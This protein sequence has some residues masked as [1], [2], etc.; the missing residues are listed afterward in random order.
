MS[1]VQSIANVITNPRLQI[2]EL[3]EFGGMALGSSRRWLRGVGGV[4]GTTGLTLLLGTGCGVGGSTPPPTATAPA[5][6]V[7]VSGA[8]PP[9]LRPET[10]SLPAALIADVDE[11]PGPSSSNVARQILAGLRA[12]VRASHGSATLP[13]GDASSFRRVAGGLRPQFTAAAVTPA[14]RVLLP[15]RSDGAVRLEDVATGA[16]VAVTLEGGRDV[17]P[18]MASGYLVYRRGHASGATVLHRASPA[19]VEDWLSFDERPATPEVTY[20]LALGAGVAG[21][22]LVEN[23]LE[24]LDVRGA[25]RLRVEPP[26]LVGAD[27]ERTAATLALEGCSVDR[28]PA[29]PWD[30]AVTAPRSASCGLRVSWSNE[31][32]AY[33]ALLDPRW[34]ATTNTMTASRQKHTATLLASGKVLVVG[35]SSGSAALATAELFDRTTGTWATTASLTGARQSHAAVL[36]GSTG[37]TTTSGKVLVTGGLNGTTSQNTAQLYD[38][39]AGTW[40]AAA[41]LPAGRHLH[42]ATL[43][44]NGQVLIAG[45]LTGTATLMTAAIYNPASGTGSWTATG[46]MQSAASN[47]TATLLSVPGNASLNNTVLVVGGNSGSSTTAVVQVLSGTTWSSS[48]LVTQLPAARE[49]HTATLLANGNVLITGGK[50]GA[51]TLNTTTVFNPSSGK[52]TWTA[53]GNLTAARQQHTATL[54]STS[55]LA[56]GQ[57]LVSGGSSGSASLSSTELWNGTSWTP[58]TALLSAVQGHTAT[59][60]ANGMVLV[61]GGVNG[62]TTVNAAALYDPSWASTCTTNSQCATGFC[63]NGVCCDTA[64]NGGCGACNLTGKVGTCSALPS[65]TTCR[66]ANGTCDVAETCS[67]TALT[68]PTD[69]FLPSTTTCRAANGTCD[70][71]EKCTGT[72]AACP[73]DAFLPST[74]TCRAATGT[75][76][77]AEKC[78]GT[79]AACPTDTFLPSTTTCRASTGT[80]D[81]AEACTGTSAACPADVLSPSTTVCRA[82]NGACDVAEKCTGTSGACPADVLSPST[83]VCRAA[84]GTCDVAESCTGTS[85]ACPADAFLPS[86]TVCRAANGTCD[87]AE[88]CTGTSAACPADGFAPSSTICRP[89]A[90][91]CDLNETCTGASASCPADQLKQNGTVCDDGQT[92]T[93]NDQCT[94]GVCGGTMVA[95]PMQG[96]CHLAGSCNPQTG[97]CFN[98]EAPNGSTCDDGDPATTGEVCEA[99]ACRVPTSFQQAAAFAPTDLGSLGGSVTNPLAMNDLGQIVGNA[100]TADGS[101]RAFV[102]APPGP[103]QNLSAPLALLPGSIANDVNDFSVVVGT[104]VESSGV[105]H[106][107]RYAWNGALLPNTGAAGSSGA[108]GG[109]ASS[110]VGGGSGSS[111][112]GGGSA[113]GSGVSAFQDLG[114]IGDEQPDQFGDR[115]SY[116]VAVNA[117]GDIVGTF[118]ANGDVQTFRYTAAT[119]NIWNIGGLYG[120]QTIASDIS[121]SGT[122]VGVSWVPNA[123]TGGIRALGHGFINDAISPGEIDINQYVDPTSGWT[124]VNARSISPDGTYIVGSGDRGG[125]LRGYRLNRTTGVLDELST[126]WSGD[127]FPYSVNNSGQVVGTGFPTSSSVLT[128]WLYTDQ[129]GFERLDAVSPT[130]GW[131]FSVAVAING[132]GSITGYGTYQGQMR[133]FSM[134]LGTS[135][136]APCAAADQCHAS[137]GCDPSRGTCTNP[138]KPN[139]TTCDDGNAATSDETCQVGQCRSPSS[140]LAISG[141]E[142]DDIGQ[143]GGGYSNA[144][145]INSFGEVVG[146]STTADGQYHAFDWQAPG[147]IID[148]TAQG[149]FLTNSSGNAINDDGTSS[150]GMSSGSEQHAYILDVNGVHDLG[151][152]GD[153]SVAPD[154]AG[155]TQQG[156]SADGMNASGQLTGWFTKKQV[157][158]AF[159]YTDGI[160]FEDVP[161]LAGGETLGFAISNAGV[162][163][164]SS[165]VPGSAGGFSA[166]RLG[167][168]FMWDGVSETSVDLND[169]IDPSM[170]ITIHLAGGFSPNGRWISGTAERNGVLIAYRLDTTTG[171]LDEV[172]NGWPGDSYG[173]PVNDHGDVSGWGHPDAANQI[174]KAFIYTDDVGFKELDTIIDP[175][176]GWDLQVSNAINASSQ[177]VGW[178]VYQSEYRGFRLGKVVSPDVVCANK[179]EGDSCDVGNTC[180]SNNVC[181]FGVCGGP[182]PA[183]N[184]C[185]RMDGIVEATPGTWIAVFGY[186]NNAKDVVVPE[187]DQYSV[188]GNL[189]SDPS[190]PPPPWLAVGSHPGAFLPAFQLGQTLSWR[191]NGQF[192]T[193]DSNS[194]QLTK[195]TDE[196]GDYVS[197]AGQRIPLPPVP[198]TEIQPVP[199]C[200]LTDSSGN[201]AVFGYSNSSGHA[202]TV[203]AGDKNFV[204]IAGVDISPTISLPTFFEATGKPVAFY[205][206]FSSGP[207]GWTIGTTRAEINVG[208]TATCQM[209]TDAQGTWVANQ[210]GQSYL[211]IPDNSTTLAASIVAP[212]KLSDGTV[213]GKTEGAFSVTA[214]GTSSYDVPLWV[215]MGQGGLQPTL[216]VDYD[217]AREDTILGVGFDLMGLS[218]QVAR[219]EK[220]FRKDGHTGAIKFDDTDAYCLDG[221]R[222]VPQLDGT[223]RKEADDS[224][225]ITMQESSSSA[226]PDL[227]VVTTATGVKYTY[228]GGGATFGG[229]RTQITYDGSGTMTHT[230]TEVRYAWS[231][232]SVQDEFGN[233]MDYT[234]D[235]DPDSCGPT[236]PNCYHWHR[237]NNIAYSGGSRVVRFNYEGRI[238]DVYKNDAGFRT[239]QDQLLTSIDVL[240][241]K[242]GASVN[243]NFLKTYEFSFNTGTVSGRTRLQSLVECDG[244]KAIGTRTCKQPTT[245]QWDD[246]SPSYTEQPVVPFVAGRQP[247]LVQAADFDGD[248]RD[249]IV[250]YYNGPAPFTSAI[251]LSRG[252]S[253]GSENPTEPLWQESSQEIQTFDFDRDGRQDLFGIDGSSLP[254]RGVVW[255]GVGGAVA[256]L[257]GTYEERTEVLQLAGDSEIL[258]F[259][260]DM[261]GDGLPDEMTG[262][263]TPPVAPGV[264]VIGDDR[265]SCNTTWNWELK[266]NRMADVYA[267]TI[268]EE[269]LLY[270]PPVIGQQLN[271]CLD[272]TSTTTRM[273]EGHISSR[274]ARDIVKSTGASGQD[275]DVTFDGTN[276]ATSELPIDNHVAHTDYVTDINGDGL[277]DIV[278]IPVT[279]GPPDPAVSGTVWINT[280]SGFLPSID[281]TPALFGQSSIAGDGGMRTMDCNNDGQQDFV[282]MGGT[283]INS[284]DASF[285]KCLATTGEGVYGTTTTLMSQNGKINIRPN[286][287]YNW[288][289]DFHLNQVMD[290]NGDGLDDLL[291]T[292]SAGFHIFTRNGNKPDL[293]TGVVDGQGAAVTV[294]YKPIIN[295]QYT[296]NGSCPY[297]ELCVKKD[298]WV[299]DTYALDVGFRDAPGSS[300]EMRTFQMSY[301][302]A[303]LDIAGRGWIG[304]GVVTSTEYNSDNVT[305]AGTVTREFENDIELG[306]PAYPRAGLMKKQ[307]IE[308]S[309]PTG[310][311]GGGPSRTKTVDVVRTITNT[312]VTGSTALGY[313]GVR[314]T[315]VTE[316]QTEQGA[317]VSSVETDQSYD[318]SFGYLTSRC[319]K[320]M[321][322][323]DVESWSYTFYP[324][325]PDRWVIGRPQ[326]VTHGS[327]GTCAAPSST[328]TTNYTYVGDRHDIE[329]D[330]V[331][332]G[333]GADVEVTTTYDRTSH[334]ALQGVTRQ[335]TLGNTITTSSDY[336]ADGV[337]PTVMKNAVGHVRKFV[338]HP[339]LGTLISTTD[340]NGITLAATYDTFGRLH[341]RQRADRNGVTDLNDLTV[342]YGVS[343]DIVDLVPV[344]KVTDSY[345]NGRTEEVDY[346]RVGRITTKRVASSDSGTAE[347]DATYDFRGNLSGVS[348]PH[349]TSQNDPPKWT[350]YTYDAL[351]RPA[352]TGSSEVSTPIVTF[353]Y[354]GLQTSSSTLLS[355]PSVTPARYAQRYT[356]VDDLGRVTRAGETTDDGRD[357]YTTYHYQEFSLLHDASIMGDSSNATTYGYDVLG[358]QQ[359][360]AKPDSG[361]RMF[362]YDAFGRSATTTDATGNTT[363]FNRDEA[364][365]VHQVVDQTGTA[366]L[367]WDDVPNGIG[368]NTGSSS[369][370]GVTTDSQFDTFGRPTQQTRA[371]GNDTFVTGMSYDDAGR[372]QNLTYPETPGYTTLVLTH[373]YDT[374]GALKT[375]TNSATSEVLWSIGAGLSREPGG[376][377]NTENLGSGLTSVR[378]HDPLTNFLTGVSTTLDVG[379]QQTSLQADTFSYYPNGSL[380]TRTTSPGTVETFGYDALNRL[381]DWDGGSLGWHVTY[382]YGDD[383]NLTNR[384]RQDRHSDDL[385]FNYGEGGAGRHAVTSN[386]WGSYQYDGAGRRTSAPGYAVN[387]YTNIDLPRS[388]STSSGLTTFLYDA[389]GSRFEKQS[390]FETDVYVGTLYQRIT[391]RQTGAVAHLLYVY[392]DERVV[393]MIE[394]GSGT[395]TINYQQTDNVGTPTATFNNN[396]MTRTF[397]DPFGNVTSMSDPKVPGTGQSPTGH[398]LG[399][400]SL[401][402][403]LGIINFG[404]RLYDPAVGRFLTPDPV[405]GDPTST[406]GFNPYSFVFNNPTSFRD[407]TGYQA[408]GLDTTMSIDVTGSSL[409]GENNEQVPQQCLGAGRCI[410]FPQNGPPILIMPGQP[411]CNCQGSGGGGGGNGGNGGGGQGAGAG[412]GPNLTEVMSPNGNNQGQQGGVGT[413][414]YQPWDGATNFDGTPNTRGGMKG[415]DPGGPEAGPA[416]GG[417]GN[418]DGPGTPSPG[419]GEHGSNEG[420]GPD[421]VNA[422]LGVPVALADAFR[423]IAEEGVKDLK[424]AG[425]VLVNGAIYS[426]D[427]FRGT[428]SEVR[429]LV[430]VAK[431]SQAGQLSAL[432]SLGH[433]FQGFVLLL[434]VWNCGEHDFSVRSLVQSGVAIGLMLAAP[435][436]PVAVAAVAAV[437]TFLDVTGASDALYSQFSDAPLITPQ[438]LWGLISGGGEGS[439]PP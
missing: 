388:I 92:C 405:V 196:L 123:L 438:A 305:I 186:D 167:H 179:N 13:A 435:L 304:F 234:Y 396:V 350:S 100:T 358:R 111:G 266:R 150:G 346:D 148:V 48:N 216:A 233:E 278:S 303:R 237:L 362:T 364:N 312:I 59:L 121:D 8:P 187:V 139:G 220:D 315:V 7:P 383:G 231:L 422:N 249:D 433:V 250:Y 356:D 165:W 282:F 30:R 114:V 70:V 439:E 74:T 20:R 285:V 238:K 295:A 254:R 180:A 21:L 41:N 174:Q 274:S 106:A 192:V 97:A 2:P 376:G 428:G 222:L 318:P 28:S 327:G 430:Q 207:V 301:Q 152:G 291:I 320:A 5:V 317:L 347:T 371:L 424:A 17:A 75:C 325:V 409:Y 366:T 184:V 338:Y 45:G 344:P 201:K 379:G 61:A 259:F 290:I 280:G 415:A 36:L 19:G 49:G 432:K 262:A 302:D 197:Y 307:T 173:G 223:F 72:S 322:A 181:H 397:T 221:V 402:G 18:L 55:V 352:T 219:C 154:P 382:Q 35:G 425:K 26:Y 389:A 3:R 56:N 257:P 200:V 236:T 31:D 14:T 261:N 321:F 337:Y 118:T 392:N 416:S 213:L 230:D 429:S 102:W 104:S 183:D 367:F 323:N 357:L 132:S 202:V 147:P 351:G 255:Q 339:G 267:G 199:F 263:A 171:E 76:D 177:I 393:A 360:V 105:H 90:S 418:D 144:D 83:T 272:F 120:K 172:S 308:V 252:T 368:K 372:L 333:G 159:R 348:A 38:P 208:E 155:F 54:L 129:T 189:V 297:P 268:S 412:P 276:I 119:G 399:E 330:T 331:Q 204:D 373:G 279:F 27:G 370:D 93:T 136:P 51:T 313:W 434:S 89:A 248:G 29:P 185:L 260:A 377:V 182:D 108:G 359:S 431:N 91:Q 53:S 80:C 247:G 235:N 437:L 251:R 137:G 211:L 101:T 214:N 270:E 158:H 81:P 94:N 209:H 265:S 32:V 60:L 110:G 385:T 71:A 401:D 169:F 232:A 46:N 316:T 225:R 193:A 363:I 127:V 24:L 86:S 107:F 6:A 68:C 87:V 436:A 195:Q 103:I 176:S 178:G 240:G 142:V 215:P 245:F 400:Q 345:G 227:F 341:H 217:S 277:D 57:V 125:Q 15:A 170:G 133:A 258:S 311:P 336:D 163:V 244:P 353:S 98:P 275:E 403:D 365:R 340:P 369:V 414:P 115:G 22:R 326:S 413:G 335:D 296:P 135:C 242:P 361:T 113:G 78:T 417:P 380:K 161:S 117:E 387:S 407:P 175:A 419:G 52:G 206:P 210:S 241:P 224:S 85:G 62:T 421:T 287:N 288:P 394:R 410:A 145:A 162:V 130:P 58:A 153:D 146:D 324:D 239:I 4:L 10:K 212:D 77:V 294:S 300:R 166:R 82:S 79:S 151:V 128:A 157:I 25:P 395:E 9:T 140:Y 205:V 423:T 246:G 67:G 12:R 343:S 349:Y 84:N 218:S 37:N 264:P 88:S 69:A 96:Q 229:K 1:H 381:Q 126:G 427:A 63:V 243:P 420:G 375:V 95:C 42:T 122:I 289:I 273:H 191:V 384:I 406:Q 198:G 309:L 299:V 283:P 11:G 44:A 306:V 34:T 334:G 281:S 293:M 386:V 164:G 73:T 124:L 404:G 50:S 408:V 194:P 269:D 203:Q 109:S 355:D 256:A 284:G 332:P 64:C 66:P 411:G 253:F 168:G 310:P 23:T 131:T 116:A 40:T 39:N 329:S 226:G 398:G 188:D 286:N 292:D 391:A 228:G 426:R 138:A 112:G 134:N 390:P 99:G 319:Q 43:L 314:P 47:H 328:R 143:L 354:S 298:V 16:A 374:H 160:G 378:S 342:T 156:A 271:D 65:K 149:G 141:L 33:P 190:P